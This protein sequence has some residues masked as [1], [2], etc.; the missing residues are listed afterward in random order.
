LE[1]PLRFE[2]SSRRVTSNLRLSLWMMDL[3]MVPTQSSWL[4]LKKTT[5]SDLNA[6]HHSLQAGTG[7]SMR[8]GASLASLA[9]PF[10][11]SSMQM[12]AYGLTA[13]PE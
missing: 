1:L 5:A 2:Q 6:P 12:F 11:A 4:W 7:S 3:P 13:S 8:V 10:S 9:T